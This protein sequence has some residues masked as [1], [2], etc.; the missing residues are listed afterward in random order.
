MRLHHPRLETCKLVLVN[1]KKW[2]PRNTKYKCV[3]AVTGKKKGEEREK[4]SIATE[5]PN[6][7]GNKGQPKYIQTS[8]SSE[9]VDRAAFFPTCLLLWETRSM[10]A[11]PLA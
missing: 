3:S 11:C 6:E 10:G 1:N 9:M 4:N 5:A 8:I 2:A 7:T